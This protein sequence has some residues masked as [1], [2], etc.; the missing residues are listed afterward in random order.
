MP[1]QDLDRFGAM[2]AFAAV[3]QRLSFAAAADE[4]GISPSAL[5]RRIAQLED[6]LG[7]RLLQRTTRRVTLTE[8]GALYLD[9]CIDILEHVL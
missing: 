9:R 3:G 2:R 6:L 7:C 8:A 4:L 5:S 1:L